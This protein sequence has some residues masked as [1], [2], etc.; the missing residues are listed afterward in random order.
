MSVCPKCGQ[1]LPDTKPTQ[2]ERV[3]T[4]IGSWLRGGPGVPSY[5]MPMSE[6]RRRVAARDR[7]SVRAAVGLLVERGLAQVDHEGRVVELTR[8][9]VKTIPERW[10]VPH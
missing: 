7:D 6:L 5:A 1:V 3:A 8:E 9:G 10:G 2:V 4:L